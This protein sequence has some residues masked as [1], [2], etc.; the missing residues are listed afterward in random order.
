MWR[1]LRPR[2]FRWRH[3]AAAKFFTGPKDGAQTGG[4]GISQIYGCNDMYIVNIEME[5]TFFDL[6]SYVEAVG[7]AE[8]SGGSIGPL[9]PVRSAPRAGEFSD[10]RQ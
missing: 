4:T 9:R 6:D 2:E 10:P 1:C 3:L 7:Q 8:Q 5:A